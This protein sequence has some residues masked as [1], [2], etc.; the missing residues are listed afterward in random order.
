MMTT[1]VSDETS[2]EEKENGELVEENGKD[3]KIEAAAI[4]KEHVNSFHSTH[5]CIVFRCFRNRSRN[6]YYRPNRYSPPPMKRMRGGD[7]EDRGHPMG[8]RF[9]GMHD[10]GMYG[11]YGSA[12]DPYGALSP[13]GGGG[14]GPSPR[15]HI[16]PPVSDG[17][18]QPAML[19]LKQFLATQDD[20]IADDVAITKYGEY[21]LEFKRGQMNEFFVSHKDEEW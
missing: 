3:G 18:F 14:G 21:K 11:G 16:P 17:M 20:S 2:S 13:Y 7:F 6:D 12:H 15:E 1:I 10:Y 8:N 5:L 19:T 9:G 4:G